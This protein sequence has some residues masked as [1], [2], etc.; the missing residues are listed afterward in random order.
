[1]GLA[2]D[3]GKLLKSEGYRLNETIHDAISDFL[4][5]VIEENEEMEEDADDDIDGDE[6]IEGPEG[7]KAER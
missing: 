4:G 7:L 6:E 2:E 5:I 1:M 3:L